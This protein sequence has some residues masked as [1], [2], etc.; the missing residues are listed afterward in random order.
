M[1]GRDSVARNNEWNDVFDFSISLVIRITLDF[2]RIYLSNPYFVGQFYSHAYVNTR[3]T[4][5]H[6][7]E[8]NAFLMGGDL[9]ARKPTLYI[10]NGAVCE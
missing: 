10:L 4:W 3:N 5:T 1:I 8:P 9:N 7:K 2:F 6:G